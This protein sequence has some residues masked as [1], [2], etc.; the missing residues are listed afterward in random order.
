[1]SDP[2]PEPVE[3]TPGDGF[4]EC[5]AAFSADGRTLYYSSNH[6][7]IDRRDLW[8]VPVATAAVR[9]QL[10][11]GDGIETYPAVLA[12]GDH[13]A[14]LFADARQPQS[15]AVLPASGGRARVITS[16]PSGF[17]LAAHV[18]PENVTLAAEDGI[19]FNS[20]LFLPPDLRPGERRPALIFIHGGSR[21]Q[22]LLGYHHLHFYHMA[23]A[24]N[25]YWASQGYIVMSV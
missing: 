18:V 5:S 14:V 7:D 20:Q 3:L 25:Q 17:P 2:K 4:V 24:M 19:E 16:L 6:S 23:Y 13:V 10:T 1:M 22:M 21:R 12:S 8:R 9:R 11:E 15:V